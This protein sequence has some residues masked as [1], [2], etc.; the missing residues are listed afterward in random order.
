MQ[1]IVVSPH[2]DD[3]V[4]SCWTVVASADDVKVVTVFTNGPEPGVVAAW[5]ADTDVDS[6]TRMRQRAEENR[7]ALA[8]AGREPVNLGALEAVY[9]G[10]D[11]DRDAIRQQLAG[12]DAVYIPAAVGVNHVNREHIVVRAACLAVRG[13]CHFYA[14][15]PYSLFRSDTELPPGLVF[16]ERRVV[17]LTDD[18]R[19]RKAE[20]IASYRGEVRKLEDHY[21]PITQP[22]RL[23]HEVFWRPSSPSRGR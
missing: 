3:A 13:D 15:Q 23:A 1:I 7:A 21:G 10:G 16:G 12:A 22:E 4:L 6:A 11:V 17:V 18:Q 8:L 14:D 20:A 5:D 19:S 9:G 2:F